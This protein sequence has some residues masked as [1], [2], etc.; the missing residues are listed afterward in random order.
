MGQHTDVD[1]VNVRSLQGKLLV[2]VN[3]DPESTTVSVQI[4]AGPFAEQCNTG[5]VDV[6]PRGRDPYARRASGDIRVGGSL[7]ISSVGGVAAGVIHG[8]VSVG[9]DGVTVTT[10]GDD[11]LVEGEII[12]T[13]PAGTIIRLHDCHGFRYGPDGEQEHEMSG[14][15]RFQI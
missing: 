3:P 9:P 15:D 14:D 1:I 6:H 12:V 10:T 13:A 7:N 8:N 11:G 5:M 4:V 2:Q